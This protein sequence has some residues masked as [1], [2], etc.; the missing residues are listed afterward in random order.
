MNLT[1]NLKLLEKRILISDLTLPLN[2][3]VVIAG[4]V[5]IVRKLKELVFLVIRDSSGKI[6]V[7]FQKKEI[8]LPTRESTVLIQGILSQK[9]NSEE[10]ELIGESIEL[11][12]IAKA[13]PIDLSEEKISEEKFRM[14]YRYLDLRRDK[15][16]KNLAFCSKAKFLASSYLHNLDFHEI[17][18]P[19]LSFSSREGA[20][21]FKTQENVNVPK[22]FTL[23][24][25]PQIY[26]QLL[27]IG[28]FEK[29]FQ[30]ATSFRAEK[31][32]EDRQY[33]FSQL[34]LELSFS[35]QEKLFEII[36]GL[37]I[38]LVKKLIKADFPSIP[39]KRLSYEEAM[40]KYGT[41]KPDLRFSP[42]IFNLFSNFRSFEALPAE[43][44]FVLKVEK[45]EL[46]IEEL[47][48]EIGWDF[49]YIYRT[50]EKIIGGN[51]DKWIS[52]FSEKLEY[53]EDNYYLF[54]LLANKEDRK[55][56]LLKM[57]TLRT[58][59]IRYLQ[60]NDKNWANDSYSFLWIID[61]PYFEE[62]EDG[63]LS[64]CH[65]PFTLPIQDSLENPSYLDWKS[66]GYDLVLNGVE[67][68]SGG[69]RIFKA[70]LQEKIFTILGYSKEEIK[71]E[72]GWFLE[73]L[74]YG[75]PPH[76]GIAIGWDRFLSELLN[77]QNI[78][79]VIAFPKNSHGNCSMSF[80][81][82]TL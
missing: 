72:F 33:E 36:E 73:A 56:K 46:N 26:K 62:G 18:T 16:H 74:E 55:E 44:C 4:F 50:R 49:N 28:G 14:K 15:L 37:L 31:M 3:K 22:S 39:F 38:F 40:E 47:K 9:R 21:T 59:L 63:K 67:I 13:L 57:G 64:T 69:Q 23:A 19:I 75:V 65:H 80:S 2:Q 66:H 10:F 27:M 42:C 25:S 61:W 78:R 32:R 12:S 8:E 17:T 53:S 71:E 45:M 1:I 11:L 35:T 48:N 58:S 51:Y 30:F 34:D 76:L 54:Y 60:K 82:K 29:Y 77:L 68:A 6:Q 81:R 79:E 5:E 7:V 43:Y 41:D 24:Q 70:E 20:E 52:S